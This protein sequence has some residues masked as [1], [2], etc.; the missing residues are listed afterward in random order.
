VEAHRSL[1][2][3][4]ACR[5]HAES[6]FVHSRMTTGCD[7]ACHAVVSSGIILCSQTWPMKVEHVVKLGRTEVSITR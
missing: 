1:P 2:V 7:A 5:S 4:V 6:S 3:T